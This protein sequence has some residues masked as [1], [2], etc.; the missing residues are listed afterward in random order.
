MSQYIEFYIKVKDNFA[1]IGVFS[2]SN[3]IYKAFE[4]FVP[5][6]DSK[7]ITFKTIEMAK[8]E[9]GC[10]LDQA[11]NLLKRYERLIEEVK[12]VNS[13]IDEKIEYINDYLEG[14]KDTQEDI[15]SIENAKNFIRFLNDILETAKDTMYYEE[16]DREIDA[17]DY[18]YVGIECGYPESK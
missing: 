14:I 2:R 10:Y 13:P 15:E 16:K 1:P 17:S 18:I 8:E 9:L 3:Y 6:E 7:P 11:D 4:S 12:E 5:Y